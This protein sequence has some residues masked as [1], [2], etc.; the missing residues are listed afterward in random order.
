VAA[1]LATVREEETEEGGPAQSGEGSNP[2]IEII[3]IQEPFRK[4]GTRIA[5]MSKWASDNEERLLQSEKGPLSAPLC[6]LQIEYAPAQ[7]ILI[8]ISKEVRGER[9]APSEK[10]KMFLRCWQALKLNLEKAD[11]IVKQAKGRLAAP[12]AKKLVQD[13]EAERARKKQQERRRQRKRAAKQRKNEAASLPA[14]AA[15]SES[16]VSEDRESWEG[17][18]AELEDSAV[19]EEVKEMKAEVAD[20]VESKEVEGNPSVDRSE[21][22]GGKSEGT[23]RDP[24]L[25]SLKKGLTDVSRRM[26]AISSARPAAEPPAPSGASAELFDELAAKIKQL[27]EQAAAVENDHQKSPTA[28]EGWEQVSDLAEKASSLVKQLAKKLVELEKIRAET[29]LRI[30]IEKFLLLEGFRYGGKTFCY[31]QPSPIMLAGREVP[32]RA[33]PW[34]VTLNREDLDTAMK[35]PELPSSV[36][37]WAFFKFHVT[38]EISK[39]KTPHLYFELQGESLIPLSIAPQEEDVWEACKRDFPD[40]RSA[41]ALAAKRDVPVL[42]AHLDKK[43]DDRRRS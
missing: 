34:H 26:K 13:I 9:A 16:A 22:R 36:F 42:A 43:W 7:K 23:A 15:K 32:W 35:R 12:V 28:E 24:R 18:E 29:M 17:E 21:P 11:E 33:V 14:L 1:A 2:L 20:D 8:E 6:L 41:L 4:M 25:N 5:E 30:D 37:R 40:L 27:Q 3:G 38:A 19:V 10:M 31:K 39:E